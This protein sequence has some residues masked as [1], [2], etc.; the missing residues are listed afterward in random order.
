MRL[1]ENGTDLP[2]FLREWQPRCSR[3]PPS[4]AACCS[5]R[6]WLPPPRPARAR[7]HTH[8]APVLRTDL[9]CHQL[10]EGLMNLSQLMQD[11]S[12]LVIIVFL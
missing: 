11:T 2:G 8:R 4:A 6:D 12:E 9:G 3:R 7:D 10:L 5:A 1:A